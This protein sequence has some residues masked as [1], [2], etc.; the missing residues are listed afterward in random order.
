MKENLPERFTIHYFET[1]VHIKT[2]HPASPF[3]LGTVFF[4]AIAHEL[5]RVVNAE[6]I[7]EFLDYVI[8]YW[9]R[10]PRHVLVHEDR[11]N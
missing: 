4:S 8:Q 10:G 11:A 3:D 1:P 6:P 7:P 5:A 9:K 2:F